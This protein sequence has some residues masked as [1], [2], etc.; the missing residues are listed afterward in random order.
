MSGLVLQKTNLGWPA[1][2]QDSIYGSSHFFPCI[3][4]FSLFQILIY[5]THGT[6]QWLGLVVRPSSIFCFIHMI[7]LSPAISCQSLV[8]LGKHWSLDSWTWSFWRPKKIKRKLPQ[9]G[10]IMLSIMRNNFLLFVVC[11][12][13]SIDCHVY[14][15]RQHKSCTRRSI[16]G[17]YV[18][19]NISQP[20]F[21]INTRKSEWFMLCL[22]L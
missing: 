12:L 13:N 14:S 20:I 5:T 8:A 6:K 15:S 7:D 4:A 21:V 1:N 16:F 11:F 2:L 3:T 22:C 9:S 19:W 18:N 10:T 17:L